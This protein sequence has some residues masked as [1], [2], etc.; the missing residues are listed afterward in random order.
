MPRRRSL[1]SGSASPRARSP[2][3]PASRCGRG[4]RRA[5]LLLGAL[6]VA[7][8]FVF[9]R[10]QRPTSDSTALPIPPQV[11]Q[12]MKRPLDYRIVN[13]VFANGGMALGVPDA[14]G[15]DPFVTRRYAELVHWS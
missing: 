12:V 15:Y 11:F 7:E 9:A 5:A 2:R 14:W 13:V 6:A 1:R 8:V 10:L 3:P 4:A